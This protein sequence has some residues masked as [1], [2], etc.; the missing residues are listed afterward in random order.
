MDYQTFNHKEILFILSSISTKDPN[1]IFTSIKSLKDNKFIANIIHLSGKM[2]I[3]N[4]ITEQT[5]GNHNVPLNESNKNNLKMN[6]K[7]NYRI[8]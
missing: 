8:L 7:N 2:K 1:D 5:N 3:C 6:S 4:L